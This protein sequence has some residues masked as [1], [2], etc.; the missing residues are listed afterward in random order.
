[1][2]FKLL[3]KYF[4]SQSFKTTGFIDDCIIYADRKFIEAR[5]IES[6]KNFDN[7]FRKLKQESEEIFLDSQKKGSEQAQTIKRLDSE[8]AQLKE[9]ISSLCMA[10]YPESKSSFD[11]SNR[12]GYLKNIQNI[13]SEKDNRIEQFNKVPSVPLTKI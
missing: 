8:L 7:E 11:N 1:M 5:V 10:A 9:E 13:L 12:I 4:S 2:D 6:E 3:K